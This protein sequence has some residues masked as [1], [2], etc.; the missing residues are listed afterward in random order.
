MSLIT[1][2]PTSGSGTQL[3]PPR[4]VVLHDDDAGARLLE[5]LLRQEGYGVTRARSSAELL[6]LLAVAGDGGG[7]WDLVVCG[8]SGPNRRDVDVLA[9]VLEQCG[10]T[11]VLFLP[12]RASGAVR[13][14][15]ERLGARWV[16]PRTRMLDDLQ[17]IARFLS[18]SRHSPVPVEQQLTG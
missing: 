8:A 2:A 5:I 6:S 4:A 1:A 14:S 10:N 12:R 11:P 17:D 13:S 15:A 16:V 7:H 3:R 18:R 9:E